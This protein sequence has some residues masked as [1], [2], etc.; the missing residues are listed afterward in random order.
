[1]RYT[2]PVQAAYS[3]EDDQLSLQAV[4]GD[5]VEYAQTTEFKIHLV[6]LRAGV[7]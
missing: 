5:H 1:M 2:A 7:C 3:A 6:I 4:G